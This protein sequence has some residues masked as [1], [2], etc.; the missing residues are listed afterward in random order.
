MVHFHGKSQIANLNL[1]MTPNAKHPNPISTI[2][3]HMI[4]GMVVTA[5]I[6]LLAGTAVVSGAA[7]PAPT[8]LRVSADGHH[9]VTSD[10]RPF[11]Y[12]AD[13][14]WELLHRL[15]REQADEYLEARATQGFTVVQTVILSEFDGLRAPNAYGELPLQEQDPTRP[16]EKYFA[17]IDYVVRRANELGLV[18]ALL[19]TWGDKVLKAWGEGPEIFNAENAR[20]FG[21]FVGRRYRNAAVV[22]VLGGDRDPRGYKKVWRA[23]ALGLKAGDGGT[24]LA[25][26]HGSGP[27]GTRGSAPFFHSEKWLDFNMYY[28]GHWLYAP[29]YEGIRQDYERKPVKPTLDGEPIYENHPYIADGSNYHQ[30]REKWDHVTRAQAHDVRR[31]AYW[32]MLAGA[33]GHTY[34]CNEVWQYYQETSAPAVT[35]AITPWREAMKFAGS[36]QMGILRRLFESRVWTR[37]VPDPALVVKGQGPGEHHIQAARASDGSLA[38]IYVTLGTDLTVN[39]GRLAPEPVRA[40]WFDPRDG[41]SEAAGSWKKK[42]GQ[43]PFDPPGGPGRGHD[44]VLVLDASAKELPAPGTIR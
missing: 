38:I 10:G 33:A 19:P 43:Q 3:R 25:T 29:V 13:T 36:R 41:H 7:N 24:H 17:H 31:V 15:K 39:L 40:W 5:V 44:W 1:P 35:E 27:D 28:S 23:L 37:L 21:E 42:G 26:F 20:A 9:L 18:V 6:A 30:H 8:R 32:A 4:M 11:F 34:G 14:A 2:D 16:N 22:W 12:L